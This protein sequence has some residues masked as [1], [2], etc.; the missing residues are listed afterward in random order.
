MARDLTELEA[1]VLGELSLQQPCTAYSIR[2]AF[3]ESPT[4]TWSSSAGTIYPVLERLE[5]RKLIRSREVNRGKRVI[6]VL[7]LTPAGTKQLKHWLMNRLDREVLGPQVD[8]LRL[9][10][11]FLSE[12]SRAQQIRFLERSIE[13]LTVDVRQAERR[14][15]STSERSKW[16]IHASRAV[17]MI[18]RARLQWVK[19]ILK[20]AR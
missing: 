12:L 2:R 4:T 14:A 19:E 17:L 10:V 18:Q 6:G 20:S 7:R 9:R 13:G 16:A 5:R 1:A 11:G 8:L 15:R 3:A